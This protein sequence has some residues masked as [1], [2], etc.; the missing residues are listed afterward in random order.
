MTQ[1]NND[2]PVQF[3]AA[4]DVAG[5]ETMADIREAEEHWLAELEVGAIK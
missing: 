3:A 2:T 1:C 4:F 5:L